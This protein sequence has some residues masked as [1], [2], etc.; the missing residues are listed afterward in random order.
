MDRVPTDLL[1]IKKT[2]YLRLLP[3]IF[4]YMNSDW[5]FYLGKTLQK[6]G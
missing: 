5:F 1:I 4:P 2:T 3:I 6:R